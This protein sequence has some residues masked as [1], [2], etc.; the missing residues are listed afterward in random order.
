MIQ[1]LIHLGL[2]TVIMLIIGVYL[3]LLGFLNSLIKT[4]Y[5]TKGV[6]FSDGVLNVNHL[7]RYLWLFNCFDYRVSG[8]VEESVETATSKRRNHL[9][10]EIMIG[11]IMI[12]LLLF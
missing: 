3:V 10:V 5:L 4:F 8:R 12:F 6:R 2:L 11:E 1:R 9:S 7:I